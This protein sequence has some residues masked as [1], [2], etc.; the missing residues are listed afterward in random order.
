MRHACV[1]ECVETPRNIPVCHFD[2]D[3]VAGN[4]AARWNRAS[5]KSGHV[6]LVIA[7]PEA[8]N[9]D[10]LT[11]S[12]L[13]IHYVG[14]H[15]IKV[16]S[17]GRTIFR[18]DGVA[19]I[20]GRHAR[21]PE[22][23]SRSVMFEPVGEKSWSQP[24]GRAHQA[25]DGSIHIAFDG[26]C[27]ACGTQ[28]RDG[29]V[30]PLAQHVGDLWP[31]LQGKCIQTFF[32]HDVEHGE[33]AAGIDVQ[34]IVS[35]IYG[36]QPKSAHLLYIFLN[37]IFGDRADTINILWK[38]ERVELNANSAAQQE[39]IC[40]EIDKSWDVGADDADLCMS[41]AVKR[42]TKSNGANQ[43]GAHRGIR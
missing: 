23:D 28:T 32:L 43:I 6:A 12:K 29:Q 7:A 8:C 18:T 15:D 39:W 16:R 1:D 35:D 17:E 37:S 31:A 21:M 4:F 2:Q 25:A 5:F 9:R 13:T 38:A 20:Q 34:G 22:E 19:H 24:E 41:Q 26:N 27:M 11:G 3:A 36:A 42:A 14:L 33:V 10:R 30:W 40:R